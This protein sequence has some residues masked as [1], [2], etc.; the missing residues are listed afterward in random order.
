MNYTALSVHGAADM[1]FAL[2]VTCASLR[3]PIS[4]F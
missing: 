1:T 3:S 2:K 4:S